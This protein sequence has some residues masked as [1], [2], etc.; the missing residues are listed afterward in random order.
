MATFY[1]IRCPQCGCVFN[2]TKGVLMSWDFSKPIPAELLD[3]TPFHCPNC[4]HKMCVLDDDFNDHVQ[5][6]INAD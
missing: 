6:V 2:I 5:T 4:N 3:E 1:D